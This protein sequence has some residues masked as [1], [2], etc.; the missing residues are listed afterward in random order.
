MVRDN[1]L[2]VS[3]LLSRTDRRAER[4]A[5]PAAGLLDLPELSAARMGRRRGRGPV[6]PRPLHL[7]AADVPAPEPAGLRRAEP[8]G[9]RGR[10]HRARTRRSRRWCC[11]TTRPTSRRRA[12][13]PSGSCA[14]AGPRSRTACAGPTRG[15][16]RGRREQEEVRILAA[17]LAK[18]RAEYKADP[19]AARKRDGH[20]PGAGAARRRASRAGGLDVGGA[21]DPEPARDDHP[22][23][24]R[25]RELAHEGMPM[26]I[27]T[28]D[29]EALRERCT[30]RAFL[31]RSAAGLGSLALGLVL[32]PRRLLAAESGAQA[33][34]PADKW[35]G[36]LEPLHFAPKA[37]RV[38]HLYLAGGPSHLELFDYKPKLAEMHGQPMPE[39]FTKGQPIAQLQRPAAHLLR[40]AAPVRALRP[41]GPG[42][43]EPASRTSATIADDICIIRSM[44][45][46]Q[47]NHDP[48]H[49][50]MNTG[51]QIS[52]RP[53]DGL[54]ALVRPRERG[55][56]LP[57]FVVL[58]SQGRAARCS[59]SPR[60]SGTAA[61]CPAASRACS[62]APR[63][64][65]SSTCAIPPASTRAQQ[66]D[67]IDAVQPPQPACQPDGVDDPEIA[68]RI[69]QYEMAFQMQTSVPGLIDFSNEP[70]SRARCYGVEGMRRLVRRQLPAGPAAGR[71]RRA[72]HPAL[73]PR[74]GPSRPH[75][76]RHR[77]DGEGGR[78]GLGRPDQGPQAARHARRH[79]GDLGR[80]IRPHADGPG[81]RPR[82]SHQG[83][84]DVAGRRR[85]QGRHLARRDRRARLP[86]RRGRRLTS[87]T[88][89]PRCCTSSASTT[90]G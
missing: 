22:V 36:V 39:S 2:A 46:E 77:D 78:P 48:A 89:T 51:T 81:R 40:P 6:P 85:H 38:I 75:Q 59:P 20:R 1:A 80:R 79:A 73:S 66:R 7:L 33:G 12:S 16:S 11:S 31:G 30:R 10:A 67:V 76:G 29:L 41:V 43:L 18:H 58:T 26:E 37:K 71:A 55:D 35:R 25:N 72:L 82:P 83:L 56:D 32:D 68:T 60:G 15:P 69:S 4:P 49:T 14:R 52:G 87:T 65:P 34:V 5:L 63:A 62:S 13:S 28:D 47:I 61:S 86:R 74:L 9:V 45:T 50:F 88:C 64:T 21:G 24:T 54:V 84:L 3:G 27:L 42:D 90:R 53:C 19:Q 70:Q 8:R 44:Q 57:G 23:M 17:L